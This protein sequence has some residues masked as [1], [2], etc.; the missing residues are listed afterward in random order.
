MVS[1]LLSQ[2]LV[3]YEVEVRLLAQIWKFEKR[4]SEFDKMNNQLIKDLDPHTADN[5]PLMPEKKMFFSKND[6]FLEIRMREL[7]KY[8]KQI[9]LI[10]EAIENPILQKFFQIDVNFDQNYEYAPILCEN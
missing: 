10:Y 3:F 1:L 5:L 2:P 6:A 9:I 4:Y 7:N 8:L